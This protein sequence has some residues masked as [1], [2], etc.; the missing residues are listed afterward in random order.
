MISG[1]VVLAYLSVVAVF[2]SWYI[3]SVEANHS[4]IVHRRGVID[5]N[6]LILSDI[7]LKCI[8]FQFNNAWTTP[9]LS[10]MDPSTPKTKV[11]PWDLLL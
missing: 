11:E 4:A 8:L 10:S 6:V 3:P 7:T 2:A 1:F 5:A 9:T